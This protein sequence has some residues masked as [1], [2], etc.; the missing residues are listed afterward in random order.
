MVERVDP[1]RGIQV[2]FLPDGRRVCQYLDDQ[3]VF[4]F[5]TGEPASP[6][7]ARQAGYPVDEIML[8]RRKREAVAAAMR[9]AEEDF[10][11]TRD[12][13]AM[14][15]E[16]AAEG[17]L[18]LVAAGKNRHRIVRASDKKAVID[19]LFSEEEARAMVAAVGGSL[20]GDEAGEEPPTSP[21]D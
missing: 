13:Y 14:L 19:Q 15:A 18:D 21:F 17:S 9:Q 11:R 2:R 1:D 6:A 20:V 8:E 10:G 3:G 12:A 7:L 5:N 4:L 16:A